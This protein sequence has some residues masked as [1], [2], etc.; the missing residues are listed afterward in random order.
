MQSDDLLIAVRSGSLVWCRGC[1]AVVPVRNYGK[2]WLKCQ[3]DHR[4][5]SITVALALSTDDDE[6]PMRLLP[7]IHCWPPYAVEDMEAER[8]EASKTIMTVPG[9][10]E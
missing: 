9:T 8:Y 6:V 7:P 5:N 10:V 3:K 2:R 4:I 1:G